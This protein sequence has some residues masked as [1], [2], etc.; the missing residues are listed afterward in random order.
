MSQMPQCPLHVLPGLLSLDESG[1]ALMAS[2]MLGH[3]LVSALVRR[4]AASLGA[5]LD[6]HYLI[7]CSTTVLSQMAPFWVPRTRTA[8]VTWT[9]FRFKRNQYR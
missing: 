4:I 2:I 7:F 8:F 9:T 3:P 1:D 5:L 6:C